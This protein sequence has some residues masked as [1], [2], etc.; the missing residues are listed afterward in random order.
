MNLLADESIDQPVIDSY[1]QMDTFTHIR[2]S[3]LALGKKSLQSAS[4]G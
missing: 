1:A 2:E 4:L 3:L